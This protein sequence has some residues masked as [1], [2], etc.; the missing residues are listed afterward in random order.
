[1]LERRISAR[2]VRIEWIVRRLCISIARR[3][4]YIGRILI[5][6]TLDCKQTMNEENKINNE[7]RSLF[8]RLVPGTGVVN[9]LHQKT[10]DGS[11][12][13]RVTHNLN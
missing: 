6:P 2:D 13:R 1:M 5:L 11:P 3:I 10:S 4:V 8:L 12:I 9:H 7:M